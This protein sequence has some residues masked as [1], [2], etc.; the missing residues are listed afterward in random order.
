[1]QSSDKRVSLADLIVLRGCADVEQAADGL[2]QL[3]E[4]GSTVRAEALLLDKAQLLTLTAPEM[5]VLIG[6]LRVLPSWGLRVPSTRQHAQHL[7]FLRGREGVVRT[8]MGPMTSIVAFRVASPTLD[9]AGRDADYLAGLR[10]PRADGLSLID[11][12]QDDFS[13]G[14]SVSSSSSL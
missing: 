3:P 1:V 5:T 8:V 12:V 6:G 2:P 13:L 7:R 14:S 9:R 10:Q 11:R 4:T